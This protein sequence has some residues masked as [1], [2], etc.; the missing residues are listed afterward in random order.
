MQKVTNS[1]CSRNWIALDTLMRKEIIIK[2][3]GLLEM[4]LGLPTCDK[5]YGNVTRILIYEEKNNSDTRYSRFRQ[6]NL[7]KSLGCRGS[8]T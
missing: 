3:I 5:P 8:G 2:E 6:V 1:M 7:G 4:H